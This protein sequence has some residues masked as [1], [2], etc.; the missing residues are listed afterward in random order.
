MPKYQY[1]GDAPTVF[2]DIIDSNGHTWVPSNGDVI[3]S[4]DEIAHPLLQLLQ[5]TKESTAKSVTQESPETVDEQQ[6]N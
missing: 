5:G 3:D 2:I 4:A 1:V 6:E